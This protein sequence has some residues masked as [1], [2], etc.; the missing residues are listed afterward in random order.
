MQPKNFAFDASHSFEERI[1]W[2]LQ[3]LTVDEKLSW[4]SSR[5][6]GCE[7]L[8]IPAFGLGGEAAH[9]VQGRND[10]GVISA[11]DVTTAFPQPI[12][13][14]ASWDPETI[15]ACG[16]V[17]GTEARVVSKRH[18]SRGLS[19]WAPTVDLE[20]DPRWGRNEEGYGEDPVL[21]G[22]MAGAYLR[23]MQGDDPKYIRTASTLKH[24]YGNNTEEGRTWKNATIDP[25]NKYELYLEPFRRCIEDFGALGI[26]TAY[27]RINGKVGILNDEVST[28]L[29]EQ[30]GLTHAVGDGGALNLVVTGQHV[31]GNHAQSVAD[32]I[33]AGVDGM[34][35][36]P[37]MVEA[38]AREAYAQGLLTEADMDKAI[39]AKLQVAMRLGCFD[40]EDCPYAAISEADICTEEAFAASRN[41]AEK[42]LV[43]MKNEGLLPLDAATPATL[44]GPMAD[45]WFQ[46]WYG[47]EPPY[48]RTVKDGLTA[49][50][51]PHTY[52]DGWDRVKLY[53]GSMAAFVEEDGSIGLRDEGD[54][55]VME[56]WGEDCYTFYCQRTG[57]YLTMRMPNGSAMENNPLGADRK[58][59]FNWFV[60]EVFHLEEQGENT[61]LL[62]RFHWPVEVVDGKLTSGSDYLGTPVK[63][64]VVEDGIAKAA[65]MAAKA[66]VVVLALGSNPVIPAKEEYDRHT[67]DLPAHQQR[68]LEAVHQ[69]N[70]NTVLVLI[71]NYPYAIRYAAA[72]VPAILLS[73]TGSQDMGTAI[74]DALYGRFSPAGR[75]NMTWYASDADLPDIDDYD[76]IRGGRTYRYFAGEP[77]YP[78]GHGLTYTTFAYS[79]FTVAQ[80]GDRLQCA[81]T[82]ENTGNIPSDEVAQL[83]GIAPASRA[84]KPRRQLLDFIRLKDVK[85][86]EKRTVE[87]S[88]PVQELRFYDV[89]SRR[90][91]VEA[92]QYRFFV[93]PSSAVEAQSTTCPVAGET[94]GKR[95]LIAIT[96]A[97]HYDDCSQIA[98][99]QGT[100]GYSSITAQ[101]DAPMAEAVYRDCTFDPE[102]CM[103]SLRVMSR[104]GGS[105][106][107]LVN[108]QA[109]GCWE[110]DTRTSEHR[111]APP[112]DRF[113]HQ[114]VEARARERQPIWEDIDFLLPDGVTEGTLTLRLAG[115]VQ[116]SFLRAVLPPEGKKIR[117]GIAN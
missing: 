100:I 82:V 91:V 94:L 51:V 5:L 114:M 7:R 20:R 85:P 19:R 34:S 16:Q 39:A 30:Y 87:F 3:Q 50:N 11:P 115:D 35:D 107:V 60:T 48:R 43:L 21:T 38:A 72:H 108:G 15:R 13:M 106:E 66:P 112:M 46:D 2:I 116:V 92:G 68:L 86:G 89:I 76:I 12:G 113:A 26:M 4:M 56:C 29:K 10:Q 84:Q 75:L 1:H 109:M 64:Q 42:S 78:F 98:I 97:D 47:G 23:G 81:F 27:N 103:L 102:R 14:S 9:G 63:I 79:G 58:A 25:R 67:I 90:L 77:L 104:K 95:D 24:F 57:T 6:P 80:V 54:E 33:K 74:A 117:L 111:S 22:R 18:G 17:T 41:A 37:V 49:L 88:V 65:A 53:F 8:G 70:P 71:A 36:N 110:G 40:G 93:G 69:A 99:L 73:A 55:F 62:N 59:A 31:Y 32:A 44:I 28:I 52:A 83:Y 101:L 105:L 96:P 45:T 61:M